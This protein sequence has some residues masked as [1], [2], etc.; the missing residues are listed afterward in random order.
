MFLQKQ[1]G[2][3]VIRIPRHTCEV[4]N[5]ST[6]DAVNMFLQKQAGIDYFSAYSVLE[7]HNIAEKFVF[8]MDQ[9][10]SVRVGSNLPLGI[11]CS[12]MRGF[13]RAFM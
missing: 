13:V 9:H 4:W 7:Q 10:V 6:Y 2:I 1:A 11:D 12:V 5:I 8:Y 3:D